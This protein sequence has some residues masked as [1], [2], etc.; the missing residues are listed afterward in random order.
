MIP[1]G[2]NGWR[3]AGDVADLSKRW[4]PCRDA[5]SEKLDT[6]D[7]FPLLDGCRDTQAGSQTRRFCRFAGNAAAGKVLNALERAHAEQ[8]PGD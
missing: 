6:R 1:W 2:R 4:T 3:L 5:S 8:I 7:E